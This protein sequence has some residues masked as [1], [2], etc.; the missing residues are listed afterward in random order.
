MSM[1]QDYD[2][3]N[4]GTQKQLFIDDYII[5]SMNDVQ[6]VLNQPDKYP[7]NPIVKMDQPWEVGTYKWPTNRSMTE[8]EMRMADKQGPLYYVTGSIEYDKEEDIYK[9]WCQ[10]GSYLLTQQSL[11]YLTS[12][13]G[14]HWEKPTLGL[15]KYRGYDTNILLE[16]TPTPRTF[17]P[18][19]IYTQQYKDKGSGRWPGIDG[20]CVFKDPVE[21]NPVE[22][23]RC[24]I[25]LTRMATLGYSAK[26]FPQ[27]AFTGHPGREIPLAEVMLRI[28]SIG[29][30]KTKN[31]WLVRDV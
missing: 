28:Q 15:V 12:K 18:R 10:I 31:I 5:E 17:G 21:S 22:D 29:T 14:I 1:Q 20:P 8:E 9:M 13:D 26:P 27:M 4:V 24:Y 3:K 7:G 16:I 19:G 6:K 30:T 23:I 2:V 25:T 11:C